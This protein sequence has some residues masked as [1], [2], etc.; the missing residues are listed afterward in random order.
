MS[1]CS[2]CCSLMQCESDVFPFCW[3]RASRVVKVLWVRRAIWWVSV[4]SVIWFCHYY[5]FCLVFRLWFHLIVHSSSHSYVCFWLFILLAV[6]V[7][8]LSFFHDF[9]WL[10]I[11]P[12]FLVS[13]SSSFRVRSFCLS[14][15]GPVFLSYFYMVVCSFPLLFRPI[16][17]W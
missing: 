11:L 12:A 5:C 14:F 10:F 6:L 7:S 2:W 13:V 9:T 1:W 15:F 17:S 3:Y 8:V 4:T 16:C